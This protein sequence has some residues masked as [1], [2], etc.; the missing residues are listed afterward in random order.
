MPEQKPAPSCGRRR[1][2]PST[3][4]HHKI[5]AAAL[6]RVTRDGNGSYG[7]MVKSVV[8]ESGMGAA[9]T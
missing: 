2:E 9:E 3:S 6:T 4:H 5:K 1:G 7:V 8:L